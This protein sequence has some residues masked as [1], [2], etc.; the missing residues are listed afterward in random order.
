MKNDDDN[1][2]VEKIALPYK[3]QDLLVDLSGPS[4]GMTR[5]GY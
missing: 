3:A 4:N 1:L 5:L 2:I